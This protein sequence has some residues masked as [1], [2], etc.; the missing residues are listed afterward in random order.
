MNSNSDDNSTNN[1]RVEGEDT[2]ATRLWRERYGNMIPERIVDTRVD[3][4]WN[5]RLFCQET[6]EKDS[7]VS[8]GN[9][10]SL[11]C[12]QEVSDLSSCLHDICFQRTL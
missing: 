2:E 6:H 3:E 1:E 11:F 12:H 4:V 10:Y 7:L 9:F 8:S 5:Y